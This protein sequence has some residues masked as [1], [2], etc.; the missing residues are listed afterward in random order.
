MVPRARRVSDR[1]GAVAP[2]CHHGAGEPEE[3]RASPQDRDR[4]RS[5]SRNSNA[6]CCARTGPGRDGR[7]AGAVKKSRGDLQ[8]GRGRMIGLEDRQ[9]LARD[10][11]VAHAAGARLKPACAIAGI[12]LR[13]LQRWQ[14]ADGLVGG[15]G[16]PAGRAPG[17]A[18]PCPRPSVRGCWPWPTSRALPPCRRRASCPC[19][20]TR[21]STWPANPP[22]AGCCA[23]TGKPPTAGAPRR[24]R[25]FG[26]RPRTSPP[27]RARCGAGT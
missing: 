9:A 24:P 6:S 3:A 10:I 22:S 23:R 20:P 13:T 19:W 1:T 12:D 26:R 5:A 14:A 17:A 15:D 11:H 21:A 18:T 2:E 8:Q 4:T 25:R 7:L 16:R 27:N